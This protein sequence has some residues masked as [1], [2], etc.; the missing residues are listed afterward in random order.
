MIQEL[1]HVF[2][3][4]IEQNIN[5]LLDQA[6]PNSHRAFMIYKVC[7]SENLWNG[8]YEKFSQHLEAF[9]SK[10]RHQRRKSDF[11]AYLERP[12]DHSVYG[13]F[14]LTFRSSIID[15]RS[16]NDLAS[17][18]HHLIRVAKGIDSAVNSLDIM[19]QTLRRITNP[20]PLEKEEN[21]QFEDF[22]EAWGKAV[23]K[24]FGAR[25]KGELEV[26]VTELYRINSELKRQ[27]QNQT[28]RMPVPPIYLTQ[29]ETDWVTAVLSAATNRTWAP[30]FPL[31]K[32]PRKRLL[33]DLERLVSLYDIVQNSELE[34]LKKH[35]E[36]IRSTILDRCEHLLG[37]KIAAAA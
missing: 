23:F 14:H 15:E 5:G 26:L 20:L 31:S 12:M 13:H 10:P 36:R 21:I 9:F 25:Y 22:C 8:T 17:W 35:R 29:T 3:R 11:D 27:E 4:L 6:E 16:L 18:A 1:W 30:G 28:N 24:S 37:R 7:Q 2:P 19:S 34:E 32:G 33:I